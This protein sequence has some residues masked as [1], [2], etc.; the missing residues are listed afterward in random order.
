M[1]ES[2]QVQIEEGWKEAL[3]DE[4]QK[5]YFPLIKQFIIAE[6]A[7]GKTVYPPGPLVFNAFNLT[8]FAELKVVI[9]GQDPYHGPGQAEG[10]CF[11]V[12][13]GIKQPPSLVNIFKELKTDLGIAPPN[14][15]SLEK[16]ARQGVLLLN[17]SLTVNA[18][19]ANSHAKCGWQVFTD[20]VIK[21]ISD[22]K[23]EIIFL[24][25]GNFAK[26]KKALIDTSKHYVLEA[27]HPSPLSGGAYFGSRHFS[28]TNEILRK[29][30]KEEIDWNTTP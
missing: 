25:W 28:K 5:P 26:A 2:T 23:E 21:K 12:A 20:A 11:S 4:F 14:H 27:A 30:G 17:A 16:W 24:L 29:L 18:G 13:K 22:E 7:K 15:G 1:S 19:E 10:L 8:P 9:L 6:K 3:K